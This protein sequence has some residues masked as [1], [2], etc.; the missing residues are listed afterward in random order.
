MKEKDFFQKVLSKSILVRIF[1]FTLFILIISLYSCSFI[2]GYQI[3]GTKWKTTFLFVD[4]I[5]EFESGGF[6]I[7]S[8]I[9][10]IYNT[11]EKNQGTY[12]FDK[13]N[14]TGTITIDGS[15]T[16]F[17]INE[18]SNTLILNSSEV[19][20]VFQNV[21]NSF[22]WPAFNL[23]S[24]KYR[25]SFDSDTDIIFEFNTSSSGKFTIV[26]TSNNLEIPIDMTYSWDNNTYSGTISFTYD[27]AN[28][29][30][31]YKISIDKKYCVSDY[32]TDSPIYCE[33]TK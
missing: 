14:L 8:S 23:V 16:T 9:E 5:I 22:S 4:M 6:V 26:D 11:V 24:L 32:D 3:E 13:Q 1:L 33:L 15:P 20:L 28:Y 7:T 31:K 17:I 29:R 18:K 21:T 27:N 25:G 10:L 12:T 19:S 30:S 2:M